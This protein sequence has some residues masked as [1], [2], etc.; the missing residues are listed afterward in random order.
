MTVFILR[1]TFA[2]I[3]LVSTALLP[4]Q[5]AFSQDSQMSMPPAVNRQISQ[6]G[7]MHGVMKHHMMGTADMPAMGGV[8]TLPGQDAFGA[9]QEIVRM[10]EA[11]PKTDWSKVDLEALRQHLIDM[12][13]VTLNANATATIVQG[14]LQ[15][16]ITGNGRTLDAI[17]RMVPAHA[18]EIQQTHL[19]GWSA[20]TSPLPNGVNLTLTS[21]KPKEVAHI[22]GLGF[23]GVMV[24]GHH[25]QPHHLA[26]AKGQF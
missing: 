18:S 3:A 26:M 1:P 19:N 16:A 4:T 17:N 5:D 25:H 14:G 6:S 12:N 24:S 11:D 20:S 23:I 13:E 21:D 8:P 15:I 2:V 22:R 7:N 10:L 9:I